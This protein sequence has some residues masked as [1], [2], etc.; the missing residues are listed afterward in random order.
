MG[1]VDCR[2][3]AAIGGSPGLSPPAARVE[4]VRDN[5]FGTT[6]EDPSR[7]MEQEGEESHRWLEGWGG[8]R[9]LGAR[10]PAGRTT[11]DRDPGGF[12]A[13]ACGGNPSWP[14]S[15]LAYGAQVAEFAR[16]AEG[17]AGQQRSDPS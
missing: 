3:Q 17:T 12:S 6:L 5:H 4:L 9:P 15:P 10:R 7:W 13:R 8:I 16:I 1:V 2:W 11:G 14:W